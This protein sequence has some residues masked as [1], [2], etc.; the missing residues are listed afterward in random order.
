[1]TKL[2][3]AKFGGSA[4]GPNGVFIPEI[5]QRIENLKK[6]SKVIAVFSAPLTIDDGKKR[7]L[8]DVILEQGRNVVN[9]NPVSLDLIKSTY[10]QILKMVNP[11]NINDCKK[12]LNSHL[13]ETQKALQEAM[14]KKEFVDEVRSRTLA[15]S[16]EILMSHVMNFILKSNGIKSNAVKFEDWPII[17]D[18]NIESTNF[19]A[20]ESREKMDKI[21]ELVEENEVVSIGGFIGKTV[22]NITT[23]YER[24][25]SDRTAADLGI[26]FHR[27]YETRIDFE[28]DSAVVSA[29]PK[30][31]ELG[32]REV[33]ELSYNEARLAGMFGMKILD[34]IAIK[35]IVENGIDMS[36]TVTNMKNPEKITTIKRTLDEQ[37]GH[38]IK[39]VTGK[40][41]CAIFRIETNS[42]QKLLTSLDKDK[43]YSEFIIL[44]PFTKVG[45]NFLEYYF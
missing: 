19:L 20:S 43:R 16:G 41:N 35:E 39:I 24:G 26:L 21:V 44:S 30:I 3:V 34:P 13:E 14:A 6:D 1:M 40:E 7:S 23:T 10:E 29:D 15:F 5:I 27:K 11:E 31:V 28:K 17:T 36:I 25:G 38:P 42:V 45:L 8:T 18:N 37:K 9:G 2:V 22:D 4:I 33:T 12:I 32:L